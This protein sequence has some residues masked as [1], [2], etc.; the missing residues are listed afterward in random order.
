MADVE[1]ILRAY[2]DDDA[3]VGEWPITGLGLTEL[4]ELFGADDRRAL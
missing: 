2:G 1:R 3:L 4:Q